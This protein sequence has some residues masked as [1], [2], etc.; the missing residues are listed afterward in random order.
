MKIIIEGDRGEGK[1]VLGLVVKVLLKYLTNYDVRFQ[2][3]GAPQIE[4]EEKEK[5]ED[6]ITFQHIR[7]LEHRPVDIIVRNP[8]L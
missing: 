4:K 6:R 2:E 3:E 1:S 5:L 8:T 7:T